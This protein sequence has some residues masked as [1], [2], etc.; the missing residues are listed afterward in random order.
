MKNDYRL[1]E[2]FLLKYTAE[3]RIPSWHICFRS[4]DINVFVLC[5]LGK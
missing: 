4:K 1:F 5:K 2:G 3:W